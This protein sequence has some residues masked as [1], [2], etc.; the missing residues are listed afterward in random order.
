MEIAVEQDVTEKVIMFKIYIGDRDCN[1]I[2]E[3]ALL[4]SSMYFNNQGDIRKADIMK[5]KREGCH[6]VALKAIHGLCNF[7]RN[8][9]KGLFCEVDGCDK[10]KD[11]S[12]VKYCGKHL[13]QI[14][15]YGKL[16]ERT[17]YNLNEFVIDGDICRIKFYDTHGNEKSEEGIIDSSD[18]NLV[19]GYKWN[20]TKDKRIQNNLLGYLH[21]FIAGH[22]PLG[23]QVDHINR[24]RLDNRRSNLRLCSRSENQHNKPMQSN[25]TSGFKGVYFDK[26]YNVYKANIVVNNKRIYLGCFKIL[27]EAGKAYDEAAIKYF[28]DFACTNEML[29]KK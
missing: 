8:E 19:K 26:K 24:N 10:P 27:Q 11:C 3:K 28:G 14:K 5:C 16:L 21:H 6:R 1:S 29:R 22:P 17:R 23:D 4:T 15:K 18:F 25:N 13:W 12:T 9:Q 20:V 7:H 2:S